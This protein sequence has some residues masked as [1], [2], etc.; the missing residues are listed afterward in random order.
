MLVL[1]VGGLLVL[2]LLLTIGG[3]GAFGFVNFWT[4]VLAELLGVSFLVCVYVAAGV[5][6]RAEALGAAVTRQSLVHAVASSL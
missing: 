6:I 2:L 3:L 5:C 1:E 4:G